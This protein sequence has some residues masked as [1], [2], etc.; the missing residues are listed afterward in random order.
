MLKIALKGIL[1]RRWRLLTTGI[2]I[3][4]GVAF[5]SGTNVLSDVLTRGANGLIDA[6][7]AGLDTVVR[8]SEA[9]ESEFSSQPIR[10]EID[11]A[12]L[13]TVRAVDGVARAE[14]QLQAQA[15]MLDKT[16]KPLPQ[17]GPPT[18]VFNWIDDPDLVGGIIKEG[19]AP[20]AAGEMALDFKT[21][22]EFGFEVG[23]EVTVQLAKGP[24]VL[25]LVGIGGLG[26]DGDKSTGSRN[27]L[28]ETTTLQQ[29]LGLEGRFSYFAV[30]A[31]DGVSQ[32]QLAASIQR[33]LPDKIE[34]VTGEALIAETQESIGQILGIITDLVAAFGWLAVFV[35]LFVIY[36]TFS[37]LIAQRTREM[38]LLRAVGAS[39]TQIL[40]SVMLEAVIVGLVAALLGMGLGFLLAAGLQVLLGSIL[41]LADEPA[42]MTTAAVVTSLIVGVLATVLSALGPAI[43]AT[44]I[45]PV[46]AISESA[47]ES[48]HIG[49]RRKVLGAV[50]IVGGA[51][52]VWLATEEILEPVLNYVGIGSAMLF[53]SVLV[54]GPTFAGRVAGALGSVLPRAFGPTGR[55]AQQNAVRNPK[56]TTATAAALTIGVGVVVVIAVI[57]SS[58][59]GTFTDVFENQI[60]AD[61]IVDSGGQIGTG[62]SPEVQES[63][64]ATEGVANV[65]SLRVGVGTLL[66]SVGAEEERAKPASERQ[67]FLADSTAPVGEESVLFAIDPD[68]FT[69][70][71]DLGEITPSIGALDDE[72]VLIEKKTA[73]ENGWE[74]GDQMEFWFSQQQQTTGDGK[75]S[76]PIRAIYDKPFAV[77]GESSIF[78][79]TT[80]F[81]EV[82]TPLFNVD[83][84][85][86]VQVDEGADRTEVKDRL[87]DTIA[88]QAPIASVTDIGKYI[89]DQIGPINSFLN[90][91][92]ALLLLAVVV[93]LVG[94]WNTLLLSIYER[95]RELGL[96]RAI[97]MERVNVRQAVRWES[98]VI[99]LFGTVMGLVL[100]FALSL[101][102]VRGFA[103]QGIKLF[104]PTTQLVIIAVGG[105][106]AGVLAALWPA[107]K[108]S[109]TDV[110]AA[111]A[112]E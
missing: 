112:T 41:P 58:F 78:V 46:A 27:L 56:R 47:V 73:E 28:L 3:V 81:E 9:Q 6:A 23:D 89:D 62:L 93:A 14:G 22:D 111:L 11:A 43:R 61:L 92:Y 91:V 25:T 50:L 65:S 104:V 44:R 53:V 32:E 57:A 66:N 102:F 10:P 24:A 54:I 82:Q 20:D 45:P 75:R 80:L 35:A 69:A 16:G 97:G 29:L 17:F 51:T 88:E 64:K 34:A 60:Q 107:F 99:A 55:I 94:I 86:Y 12:L 96:L 59:K 19:E 109:R 40:G 42:R 67:A 95:T 72:G 105:A 1:A 30:K 100:G 5:I 18:F 74:V 101:A 36:N 106:L 110:L 90:L 76:L 103:D 85:L 2:A 13:D 21:A 49:W 70:V 4:L 39:R 31:D 8:S 87:S 15:T 84:V 38:A 52:L 108:A 37:I 26:E 63:V 77:F 83:N 79:T 33:V 7:F 48:T 71:I 68:A 98:A